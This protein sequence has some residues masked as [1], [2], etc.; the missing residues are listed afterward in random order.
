MEQKRARNRAVHILE[1]N[2]IIRMALQIHGGCQSIQSVVLR[3][4]PT[5]AKKKGKPS[6][7]S[8]APKNILYRAK[9]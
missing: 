9:M 1:L 8:H 3:Q 5:Y 6:I 2:A 4:Q 7:S